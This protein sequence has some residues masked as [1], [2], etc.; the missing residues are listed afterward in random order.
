MKPLI[1]SLGIIILSVLGLTYQSDLTNYYLL[2][3]HL[4]ALTEECTAYAALACYDEAEGIISYDADECSQ[5]VNS[6]INYATTH[7]PCFSKE[8]GE[9][10]TIKMTAKES[11][12]NY[13]INLKL[14]FVPHQSFFR[15]KSIRTKEISHESCYEWVLEP[16]NE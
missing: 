9:I 11:G 8:N 13:L 16:V 6:L 2:E 1:V 12:D 3:Q 14:A 10:R 15:L 7:M 5:R 4:Q